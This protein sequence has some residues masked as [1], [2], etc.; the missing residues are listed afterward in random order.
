LIFADS[1]MPLAECIQGE[2]RNQDP[3]VEGMPVPKD[4]WFERP[5]GIGAGIR[6]SDNAKDFITEVM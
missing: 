2:K 4:G 1:N 5:E 6:L 3:V